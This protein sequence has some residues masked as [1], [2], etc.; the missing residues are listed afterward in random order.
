MSQEYL[1]EAD[2]NFV[3]FDIQWPNFKNI[4]L[5]FADSIINNHIHVIHTSVILSVLITCA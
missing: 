4:S 3:R 2:G 5:F 1:C